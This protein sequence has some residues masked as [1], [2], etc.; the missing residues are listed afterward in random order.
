M[1]MNKLKLQIPLHLL[2]VLLLLIPGSCEKEQEN[3]PPVIHLLTGQQYT[4]D[5]AVIA[6][7][8]IL[9]FGITASGADANITNFVIKKVMPDGSYK[10]VLDSGLNSAGF[11][12]DE[13]FYQ[14]VEDTANWTF[15]VMDKNRLF[16]TTSITLYKDPNSVWGGIHDYPSVTLG[17]QGNTLA[18]HFFDPMTG[19]IFMSDSAGQHSDRI[20]ITVYYY[21]DESLPSPT[22]SS[23]GEYGGGITAYYPEI[24]GWSVKLYTKYDISVDAEPVPV[25]AFD[26]CHNDSLLILSYDE[27][28]GK[29]KF[30]WSDPGDVIPFLTARGKKGLI[31]VTAADHD[32]LGTITFALKIQQ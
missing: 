27:V 29:R 18:G 24:G 12:V 22:F 3:L 10:V 21:E 23:P 13:V 1:N 15:Q 28:W 6:T 16:A 20:D 11:T 32:P 14:G 30:K 4:P 5:N 25:S 17:Y 7:G 19:D 9:R 26:A 8:G 31:K 2:A